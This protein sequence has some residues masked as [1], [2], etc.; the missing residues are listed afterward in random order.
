MIGDNKHQGE[1]VSPEDKLQEMANAA[2]KAAGGAGI[3]KEELESIINRAVMRIV[4]ALANMGFYLDSTQIAKATQEARA[5]M[6]IRG[7]SVEVV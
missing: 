1:I 5:A 7:N 6:D 3:S 4:A 2:A